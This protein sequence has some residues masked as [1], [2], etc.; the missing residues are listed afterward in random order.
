MPR[1]SCKAVFIREIDEPLTIAYIFEL[2][3]DKETD[4][5][6]NDLISL[7]LIEFCEQ[8]YL[9]IQETRYL[10]P[11]DRFAPEW[12]A[13]TYFHRTKHYGF[14]VQAVCDVNRRFAFVGVPTSVDKAMCDALWGAQRR[15]G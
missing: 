11:R 5:E 7:E 4:S 8:I 9:M 10:A 12:H 14:N 6:W 2:L 15:D 3:F 1:T 13:E